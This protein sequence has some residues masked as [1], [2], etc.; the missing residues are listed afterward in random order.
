MDAAERAYTEKVPLTI[1][2]GAI[3]AATGYSVA[4]IA[5]IRN[6]LRK[7]AIE[8]EARR[9]KRYDRMNV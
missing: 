1:G 7:K 3:A 2:D 5:R 4:E 9:Q 6:P 8:H